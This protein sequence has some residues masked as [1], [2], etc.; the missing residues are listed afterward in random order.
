VKDE[1]FEKW[2]LGPDRKGYLCR[3]CCQPAWDFATDLARKEAME[4]T[5]EAAW[6]SGSDL[7]DDCCGR[8]LENSCKAIR[9]AFAEKWLELKENS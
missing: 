7:M 3:S 8:A 9:A 6:D 4:L 1:T 2:Y 5:C